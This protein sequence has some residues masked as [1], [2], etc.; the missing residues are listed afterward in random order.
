MEWVIIIWS[1]GTFLT[2][3]HMNMIGCKRPMGEILCIVAFTQFHTSIFLIFLTA[4]INYKV[5]H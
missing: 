2:A 1:K 3:E 5:T 4:H